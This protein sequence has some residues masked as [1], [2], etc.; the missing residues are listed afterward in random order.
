MRSSFAVYSI[1]SVINVAVSYVLLIVFSN[2]LTKVEYAAYGYYSAIVAL[3]LILFNFGHKETFFK[4]CS[5]RDIRLLRRISLS[6]I[7][8]QSLLLFI[9][10][11]LFF[12][13]TALGIITLHA[14]V[15]NW[16][17]SINH[18]NRGLGA[19]NKDALAIGIHRLLWLAGCGVMIWFG[20]ELNHVDLFAL[21]GAASV[22]ILLLFFPVGGLRL[23]HLPKSAGRLFARVKRA[24]H[25]NHLLFKYCLIEFSTVAY[26]KL[27]MLFLKYFGISEPRMAEYFL[28]NQIFEAAVMIV[29][30]IGYFFFNQYAERIRSEKLGVGSIDRSVLSYVAALIGLVVLGQGIWWLV[31]EW[32]LG[33]MFSKYAGSFE[34]VLFSLTAL[35]PVVLNI[36]L[37]SYLIL[38]HKEKRYVAIC[39]VGLAANLI[40]N[41]ILIPQWDVYGAIYSRIITES[42]MTVLLL[43]YIR[44][45]MQAHRTRHAVV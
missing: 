10:L 36:I 12:V 6:Y 34:L 27:D 7:L 40:G 19:Y 11:A 20:V 44:H 35:Y 18:V 43:L 13:D 24:R 42:V 38:H 2:Y 8:L 45:L 22:L 25:S 39:L 32:L 14:I 41:T 5:L 26:L 9:A 3:S 23:M 16:V 37:S 30:P 28:S 1:G 4:A 21:A 33:T 31:G 17:L 29:T 15:G